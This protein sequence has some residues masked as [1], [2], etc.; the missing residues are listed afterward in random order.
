MIE[1]ELPKGY[2]NVAVTNDNHITSDT[3]D[4]S[5]WDTLKFPLPKGKWN[6]HSVRGKMVTLHKLEDNVAI[7]ETR[8][9]IEKFRQPWK[10][11][12]RRIPYNGC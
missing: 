12:D 7:E 4:S 8:S 3:N 10:E 9:Q 11:E 6:I 5:N 2:M 1:I